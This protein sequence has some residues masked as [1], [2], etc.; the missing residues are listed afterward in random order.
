[1]FMITWTKGKCNRFLKVTGFI[2]EVRRIDGK[3]RFLAKSAGAP[4]LYL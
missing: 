3:L 1:M 4:A 2:S